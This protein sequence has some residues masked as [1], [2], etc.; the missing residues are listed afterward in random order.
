[1]RGTLLWAA[2]SLVAV[3]VVLI[4]PG[5]ITGLSQEP[6]AC[7]DCRLQLFGNRSNPGRKCDR[8]A[9]QYAAMDVHVLL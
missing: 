6:G 3:S 5:P 1:M 9:L 4:W 7:W 8:L 2:A